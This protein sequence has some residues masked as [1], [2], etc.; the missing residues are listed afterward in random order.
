MESKSQPILKDEK[1]CT[2]CGACIAVCPKN[3]IQKKKVGFGAWL[4]EIDKS[5]CVR[6][7]LCEKVCSYGTDSFDLDTVKR[8]EESSGEAYVAYNRN[9]KTRR[10]SASGGVFSALATYILDHGGCVFGAEMRFEG[11]KAVVEH[12]CITEIKEL[13]RILGSK[14]VQSDCIRAYREA[15]K[16]LLKGSMVLFSG[17][18]CQ[19]EGLLSYLSDIDTTNLY[20]IDLICHGTPGIELFNDYVDYLQRKYKGSIIKFSFRIKE[21]TQISYTESITLDDSNIIGAGG[22]LFKSKILNR[23]STKVEE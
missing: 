6:C 16:E 2:G 10:Q 3:A 18:S 22:V 14:Y 12:S 21:P 1:T 5:L 8:R 7:R 11:G 19:I 4:P 13:S 20:T 23:H 9:M 17:C 15:K